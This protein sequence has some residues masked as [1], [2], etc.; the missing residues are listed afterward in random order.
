M[1]IWRGRAGE[2]NLAAGGQ[3]VVLA[4]RWL[5]ILF[6]LAITLWSP[7]QADLDK[8]RVSLF[9]LLALAIGNFFLNAR[10]LTR[11]RLPDVVAVVTSMADIGVIGLLTAVF[12]GLRAPVFV[13]Y[14]PAAVA[15]TLAFPLELASGLL[16]CL[17]G[18]Y[19]VI[20][21]PGFHDP[22]DAQTLVVRLIAIAGAASVAAVF[23][24][25]EADRRRATGEAPLPED[26]TLVEPLPPATPSQPVAQQHE[27]VPA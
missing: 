7:V 1:A 20:C 19:T 12:G 11:E 27:E 22:A 21:I 23:R 8:V 2:E 26:R 25:I 9:V 17:L 13:F 3:L 6:G 14:L 16:A 5:L 18:L 4:A 15:L 24:R 10:A